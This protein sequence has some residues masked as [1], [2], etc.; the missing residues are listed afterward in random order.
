[1]ERSATKAAIRPL[2]PSG[3]AAR[4]SYDARVLFIAACIAIGAVIAVYALTVSGPMDPAMFGSM[5]AFP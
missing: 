2:F 3:Q 5:V 4:K 1:M